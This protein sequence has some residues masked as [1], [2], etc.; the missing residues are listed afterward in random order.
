MFRPLLIV[1]LPTMIPRTGTIAFDTTTLSLFSKR[2]LNFPD[3][4]LKYTAN[5]KEAAVLVPLC[6]AQG[7]PS[8]LFTVRNMKMRTHRGE[9]R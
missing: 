1:I 3:F 9:I 5:F 7:K 4:K 2:L 6:I 8:V